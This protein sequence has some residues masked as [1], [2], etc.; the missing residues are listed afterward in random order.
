MFH[1][2]RSVASL[3]AATSL[4]G[5]AAAAPAEAQTLKVV[6]HSDLKILDP[7]WTTA[8]IQRNHGYMVWDTLFAMD[9]QFHVKPQMVDKFDVSTDKLTWTF[10][11]RDGLEWSD[12]KP[13]TSD[14]CIASIKR[15]AA[16]D[17][18]GQKMMGSVAGFEVVDAKTFKMKMKEP[19]GLVLESL[20]KPSSNVPFMMPKKTAETDPSTQ[21]KVEDVIGSGPFIFK[22]NEWKPGEKTVYVKNPTYKPRTEPPSGLAG[23]KV[24]KLDRVEW[25][26]MPDAQ[27]QVSALQNGEID[28]IE[29]PPHDLLPLLA[30]DKNIKLFNGNPLGNQYTFRFNSTAKPF[31]NPKVRHAVFVAFQQE[32]FLKATIGDPKWYKVC[33]APFVCG[34]PLAS[35]AGMAEVLNGDTAKAKQLLQEA[36]YD[37]TPIVLMQST[38]LPVLTNLAPVAKQLMERAGFKVDMQSMDWQT[39]VA[40]RTKKDA[41]DKGGWHAFLTSWVAADILNPVMAGFFNAACDK[42]MFGWPCDQTIEKYRDQFAKES[43]PAKQK[44]IA[45]ALQKYWVDHP[46]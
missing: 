3:I 32:E 45:I 13:V 14:D 23:G 9:E 15:W 35:D 16:K 11:L 7:I 21:I 27:T 34:T 2:R 33:K 24:V 44:E 37:G 17:S 6:M 41:P 25:I 30:A 36:G 4:A 22:A 1:W 46:T 29:S 5:M 31:D 12:G 19:Y 28:M 42:A 39:L 26:A 40:R 18:M 10:A 38:D 8:Y 20:G 43:D